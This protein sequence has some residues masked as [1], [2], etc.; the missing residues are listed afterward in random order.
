[1]YVDGGQVALTGGDWSAS[2][3]NYSAGNPDYAKLRLNAEKF[4]I[5]AAGFPV[6]AGFRFPEASALYGPGNYDRSYLSV[7]A[8]ET[9]QVLASGRK[10]VSSYF[11][12]AGVSPISGKVS[13]AGNFPGT[14][15]VS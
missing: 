8:M 15:S 10:R 11:Q 13:L 5:S 12:V 2:E 4:K 7:G 14:V 9:S 6:Y 3:T 1:M